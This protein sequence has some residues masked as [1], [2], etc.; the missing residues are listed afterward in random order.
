MNARSV[1]F[2]LAFVFFTVY[3]I[4]FRKRRQRFEQ[5][6]ERFPGPKAYPFVGNVHLAIGTP[7]GKVS[8]IYSFFFFLIRL[9]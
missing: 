9:A 5:M 4:I 3:Y 8:F 1:L 6:I 2:L 7:A